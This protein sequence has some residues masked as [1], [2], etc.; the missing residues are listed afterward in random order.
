MSGAGWQGIAC[1]S[2]IRTRR[3]PNQFNMNSG[4]GLFRAF[5]GF[6]QGNAAAALVI[7]FQF[8]Q[9]LPAALACTRVSAIRRDAAKGR[10]HR[11]APCPAALDSPRARAHHPPVLPSTKQGDSE[12]PRLYASA[13]ALVAPSRGEGWG[14]PHVEVGLAQR[15]DLARAGALQ[16]CVFSELQTL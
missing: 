14:R 6:P 2:H 3:E 16:I 1:S 12:F 8:R 10:A 13:D 5:E 4:S 9:A 7:E 15:C 11:W